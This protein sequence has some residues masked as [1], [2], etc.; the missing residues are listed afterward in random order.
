[1]GFSGGTVS[2]CLFPAERRQRSRGPV[3]PLL[4][5]TLEPASGG[6]LAGCSRRRHHSA[7]CSRRHDDHW[8]AGRRLVATC[9]A[10]DLD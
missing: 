5:A 8:L 9:G 1:L 2:V 7:D 4:L 10:I 6:S 3:N